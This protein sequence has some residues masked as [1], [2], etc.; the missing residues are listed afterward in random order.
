MEVPRSRPGVRV[1]CGAAA[2]T[3]V[4][5][6]SDPITNDR[7]NAKDA[8]VYVYKHGLAACMQTN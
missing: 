6:C 5:V 8:I 1:H 3:G 4:H 7:H 2:W